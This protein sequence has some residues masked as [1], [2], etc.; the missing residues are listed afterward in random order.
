[1]KKIADNLFLIARELKLG[2][3]PP[4]LDDARCFFSDVC[5]CND[6]SGCRSRQRA[7]FSPACGKVCHMTTITCARQ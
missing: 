6:L 2:E 1:M 3:F 4:S 5:E 7:G